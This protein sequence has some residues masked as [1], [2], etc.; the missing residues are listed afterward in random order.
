M[1]S[2]DGGAIVF[3]SWMK[4]TVIEGAEDYIW[5]KNR[6]DLGETFSNRGVSL[7]TS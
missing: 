7:C 6:R 5:S 2:T 1:L 3:D 4:M